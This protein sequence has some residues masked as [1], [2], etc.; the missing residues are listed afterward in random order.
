MEERHVRKRPLNRLDTSSGITYSMQMKF[1]ETVEQ[2]SRPRAGN[3]IDALQR[4]RLGVHPKFRKDSEILAFGTP[5]FAW[6][7]LYSYEI[8]GDFVWP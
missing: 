4:V 2:G 7:S 8:K 5:A 1:S 6:R 3:R